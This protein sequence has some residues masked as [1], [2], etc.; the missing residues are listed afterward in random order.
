MADVNPKL[1]L[2]E[3]TYNDKGFSSTN[4]ISNAL[5][6][7]SE[8]LAPVVTHLYGSDAKWGSKNFPLSFLT[9][10]MNNTR[11]IGS[12][13]YKYPVMGRPKKTSTIGKT[14]YT[15]GDKPGLGRARF[16]VAFADRWFH[17]SLTIYS[18]NKVQCRVMEDPIKE[19][20]YWIYTLQLV[21]PSASAYCPISELTA[22]T[23]W[24]RGVSKV[25]AQDSRGVESRGMSPSEVT[26]QLSV[27]RD[28]YKYKGNVNN[29]VM[30]I[31]IQVDGK[32]FKFWTEFEL[33]QRGLEFREKCEHDLWYS[34]YN[35]DEDGQIH[36]I[37]DDSGEVIP[38]GSG[39]IEQIPNEDSYTIMTTK[40]IE[41]IITD[42]FYNANDATAVEV[43]VFTGLGG[44]READRAMK[45]ASA[46]FTLVDSKQVQ[47]G[48]GMDMMF[49]SYFNTYRHIDGHKVTF[50]H[51][52][53]LDVGAVSEIS[54]KHPIDGLPL[55]SYSMYILDR[56]TYNGMNNIL[57]VSEKGREN[58]NKIV[59][60]MATPPKGYENSNWAANDRDAGSVEW[61]KSQGIQIMR[62]TNCNKIFCKI[63]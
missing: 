21:N 56:S 32:T 35:K 16:K 33:Y 11:S 59:P 6:S 29:K 10:G 60:G 2:Y 48:P 8:I 22:G 25:S 57:Y 4:H 54:P 52:P 34:E 43:D 23:T 47:G 50:R 31:E 17:K 41:Q 49:G 20:N 14:L 19:G 7:K 37:D 40:K 61:M 63:S 51:L 39:V 55:E 27:V 46:G 15:T 44:L 30:V 5:Q 42:T 3:D 53:L 18:P 62:P 38:F 28:T 13:D 36:M 1:R 26:N 24:G 12:I 45:K 58:I 9:E